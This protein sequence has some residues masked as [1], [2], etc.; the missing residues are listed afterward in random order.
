MAPGLPLPRL[1]PILDT[2]VVERHGVGC[3]DAGAAF[4]EAGVRILQFRH[5]GPFTRQV[6]EDAEW[7]ARECRKLGIL[8]IINDRA[9][10]ARLLDAGLHLGQDD[11]LPSQSR[12]VLPDGIIGYS[13]HNPEQLRAAATEPADYLAL[14]PLFGTTSKENPDPIVGVANFQR[15][16]G[17]TPKPLVAIGGITRATAQDVIAAGADSLAVISDLYPSGEG[18]TGIRKRTEEWLQL[19][20]AI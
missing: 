14:G 12:R 8:W 13:T 16:R 10:I 7:I 11:L 3:R 17:L 6:F 20:A 5:K 19:L 18:A 4:L 2:A 1:Y 9:D 15:W